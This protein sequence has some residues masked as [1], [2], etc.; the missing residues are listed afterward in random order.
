L[1]RLEHGASIRAMS[2]RPL[3]FVYGT[4][5]PR[6]Q[7]CDVPLARW[8]ATSAEHLGAARTRGRLYDLGPYPGLVLLPPV[9]GPRGWIAGDVY[10]LPRPQQML[11][12][13]DRYEG[14]RAK[15]RPRFERIERPIRIRQ[16]RSADAWLYVYRGPL[17]TAAPI[18]DGDYRRYLEER[19]A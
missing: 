14:G 18:R 6:L 19:N 1:Q 16:Y 17:A 5:R 9:N 4:L 11:A 2:A 15:A 13:L 3:L 8:L 10:R 7:G 12:T